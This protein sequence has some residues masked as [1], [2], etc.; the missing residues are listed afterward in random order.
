MACLPHLNAFV[1]M[2]F[3][4]P[5][6]LPKKPAPFIHVLRLVDLG[7]FIFHNEVR[8]EHGRP[9]KC[10]HSS[11]PSSLQKGIYKDRIAMEFVPI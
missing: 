5:P 8:I 3:I 4:I 7:W 10:C 2:C 11:V 1:E 6:G 9:I